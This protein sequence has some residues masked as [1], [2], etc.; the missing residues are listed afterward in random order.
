M[1]KFTRMT[2]VL[3]LFSE[4]V[5]LLTAEDIAE[6][7][8][9]SR[10]TAF[11]YA[12]ELSEAGFLANFA[13]R[14]A[15]GARIITLDYRIRLSDPILRAAEAPMETLATQSRCGVILCRMYNDEIVNVHHV[16]TDDSVSISFGRG[17]PLPL[18][19][20]SASK[21]ILAFVPTMRLKKLCE[22]HRHDEQLQEIGPDW[23]A[24]RSYFA[25]I[26][27]Q[28]HYISAHEVDQGTIGIGAPV[29]AHG[30]APA[31]LSLVYSSSRRRLPA[32]STLAEW[33]SACAREVSDRLEAM[34][35]VV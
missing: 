32:Q 27:R 21:A 23:P 13:G 33:V 3:D 16:R 5:T 1:A 28:G 10:P 24:W 7:L 15:L 29:I 8:E 4:S 26:R 2:D 30:A 18:F 25:S 11:R 35:A 20:G 22:R 17:R 6:R 34:T 9:V 19:R 14:Y 31:S 12:R